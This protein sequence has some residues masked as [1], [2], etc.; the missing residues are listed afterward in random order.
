MSI[1]TW[2]QWPC[3]RQRDQVI[4]VI[5]DARIHAGGDDLASFPQLLLAFLTFHGAFLLLDYE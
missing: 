1:K 4:R 2:R 3:L 5:I